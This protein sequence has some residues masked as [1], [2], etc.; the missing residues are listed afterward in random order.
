MIN[1][2]NKV[3]EPSEKLKRMLNIIYFI[4]ISHI[5]LIIFD[6]VLIE[7]ELVPYTFLN[8]LILVSGIKTVYFFEFMLFILINLGYLYLL[9]DYIA[10]FFQNGENEEI[11]LNQFCFLS[12]VSVFEIF[13][14]FVV[15]QIYKQSKQEYRIKMGYA[16]EN[17]VV[18]LE[19][20]NIQ[21]NH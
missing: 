19:N 16:G 2:C 11:N 7:T 17:D 5:I 14:I 13:S 20:D 10:I 21:G 8:Q 3:I 15:F 4:L 6:L 1:F 9:I 12:A 18:L